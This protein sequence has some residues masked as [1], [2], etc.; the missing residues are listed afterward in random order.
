M[1]RAA[2]EELSGARP[3]TFE[4]HHE[5]TTWRG[6]MVEHVGKLAE[7]PDRYISQWLLK[8]APMGLS[9]RVDPG[10]L[11]PRKADDP[12]RTVEQLDEIEVQEKNH[13]SYD[14][15]QGEPTPPAWKLLQEQ[16]DSGFAYCFKDEREAEEKLGGKVHPSPLGNVTTVKA[17]GSIKHR[18]IQDQRQNNVNASV[19]VPERQVLPRGVDHGVDLASLNADI[20]NGEVVETLILDFKDA[21]MSIPVAP[22]ER[23]F[24]CARTGFDLKR[25]RAAL[26]DDETDVANF[27]VWRVLGFGGRANPLIFARVASFACRTAQAL[28]GPWSRSE[29][30]GHWEGLGRGL[31]QLFVDDPALTVSG[32]TV[33]TQASVDLVVLWWLLLGVPLS[34][35]KGALFQQTE[36][37]TWIGIVYSLSPD[38]AIMRL[39][40]KF[41]EELLV[42]LEPLA[43]VSGSIALSALDVIIGKCARV[44]HVVPSARPFVGAMWGALGAAQKA[45]SS[46]RKEAPPGHAAVKRFSHAASWVRALLEEREECPLPLERL[47]RPGRAPAPAASG[48]WAEFDASPYGGGA[49]LRN[50]DGDIM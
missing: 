20:R 23:R 34:W 43:K 27:V 35:K 29:R 40:E 6:A 50:P 46:G 26:F 14:D 36:P 1:L 44:A 8:G 25:T 2:L 24:N 49:I 13:Q 12:E 10:G 39:P 18:L 45:A 9:C 33:Q 7:D 22:Q 4:Q 48:W 37:H 17:D 42:L 21:F 31:L 3:G 38:G 28:L 5:A 41:V 11:F 16:V 32:T 19:L 15:A 47:V 30:T